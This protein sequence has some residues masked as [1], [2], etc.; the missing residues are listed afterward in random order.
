[1]LPLIKLITAV[2]KSAWH[3]DVGHK[4]FVSDKGSG[5]DVT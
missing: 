1:M 4:K 5:R 2:E 3:D